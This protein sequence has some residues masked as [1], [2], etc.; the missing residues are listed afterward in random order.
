MKKGPAIKKTL[1]SW[2]KVDISD[3]HS[4][5]L[6]FLHKAIFMHVYAQNLQIQRYSKNE[7]SFYHNPHIFW[8][9]GGWGGRGGGSGLLLKVKVLSENAVL[10][11]FFGLES[12][13]RVA[14]RE[15]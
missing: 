2:T 12:P 13:E 6:L 10:S 9:S 8:G 3:F 14:I 15:Q 1:I 5:I 4:H 7:Y 11:R